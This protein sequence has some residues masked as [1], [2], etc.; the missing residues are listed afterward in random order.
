MGR[1][2][3]DVLKFLPWN[4]SKTSY[5]RVS[6]SLSAAKASG[7]TFSGGVTTGMRQLSDI[8]HKVSV[9]F[10]NFDEK[11]SR[12]KVSRALGGSRWQSLRFPFLHAAAVTTIRVNPR[13]G[14]RDI[15]QVIRL[16]NRRPRPHRS[17]INTRIVWQFNTSRHTGWILCQWMEVRL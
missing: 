12:R 14:S 9:K 1:N 16:R 2:F 4:A 10:P 17:A 6:M 11:I 8:D 15:H 13:L 5:C 3:V 7:A